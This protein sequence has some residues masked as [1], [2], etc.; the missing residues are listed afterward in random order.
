M[1][2]I[3]KLTESDLTRIVKRV[4]NERILNE[5]ELIKM[6]SSM[7]PGKGLIAQGYKGESGWEKKLEKVVGHTNMYK[8]NGNKLDAIKTSKKEHPAKKSF[9]VVSFTKGDSTVTYIGID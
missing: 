5:G 1:K 8:F 2:R 6:E 4:I 7:S 9:D 3:I